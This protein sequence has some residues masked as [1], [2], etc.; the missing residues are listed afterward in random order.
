MHSAPAAPTRRL[1][2]AATGASLFAAK[3][4]RPAHATAQADAEMAKVLAGRTPK[5]TGLKLD[6][7]SIAENGLVVPFSVE[8]DSPMT[9]A[10]HIKSIHVFADGNPNPLVASF[11]F[12][13]ESGK[14]AASTRMR[15]AQTQNIVAI[16]ETSTGELRIARGEVKVT[17]GGCGG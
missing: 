8:A 7:P 14:A 11:Q 16:A 6:V 2:L 1:L 15:L 9:A 10:D 12:T 13:P 4:A 5:E 3:L 17:I